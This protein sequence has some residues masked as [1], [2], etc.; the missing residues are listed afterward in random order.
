[1]GIRVLNPGVLTTVQDLGRFG[2]QQFGI[3]CS[4]VMDQKSFHLTLL[5]CFVIVSAF[6]ERVSYDVLLA[7]NNL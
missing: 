3:P 1:M 4:G 5:V 6:A 2:Y 7:S